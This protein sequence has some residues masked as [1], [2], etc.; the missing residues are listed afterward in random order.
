MYMVKFVAFVSLRYRKK[1]AGD[2]GRENKKSV[3]DI[4]CI[5]HQT[6]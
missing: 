4:S 6:V 3:V 1:A 5:V 2:L